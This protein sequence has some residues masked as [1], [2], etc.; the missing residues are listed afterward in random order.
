MPGWLMQFIPNLLPEHRPALIAS[1][2]SILESIEGVLEE[3]LVKNFKEGK[4]DVAEASFT[5]LLRFKSLKLFDSDNDD[6]DE[7][8]IAD[9]LSLPALI[10]AS[11]AFPQNSALKARI[12]SLLSAELSSGRLNWS[13]AA[14]IDFT[15]SS[16]ITEAVDLLL[17]MIGA[18]KNPSQV[19][20]FHRACL[21][22]PQLTLELLK[23]LPPGCDSQVLLEL[24]GAFFESETVSAH[25][26][27]EDTTPRSS[28]AGTGPSQ[29]LLEFMKR[30]LNSGKEKSFLSLL[31]ANSSLLSFNL[32][33]QCI[34]ISPASRW[35]C[36]GLLKSL[37]DGLDAMTPAQQEAFY[38]VFSALARDSDTVANELL[39]LLKKQLYSFD[40]AYKKIGAR[41]VV[42]F[43]RV[44]GGGVGDRW[45]P[46]PDEM[47]DDDDDECIAGCSQ[48]PA[49]MPGQ[50]TVS[51]HRLPLPPYSTRLIISLLE[52]AVKS[53]RSHPSAFAILLSGLSALIHADTATE[54]VEWIAEWIT[55]FFKGEFIK[56]ATDGD[57]DDS[58]ELQFD[59]DE[60]E[61]CLYLDLTGPLAGVAPLA[62]RLLA[63]AESLLSA[64]ALDA[65]DALHGCPILLIG[66]EEKGM[67]TGV[68]VQSRR[69]SC[70]CL[71]RAIVDAFAE[72]EEEQGKNEKRIA[73]ICELEASLKSSAVDELYFVDGILVSEGKSE[74]VSTDDASS[75][76]ASA[77]SD[78]TNV[79]LLQCLEST[80]FKKFTPLRR[81]VDHGS[82][83]VSLSCVQEH[84]A[85]PLGVLKAC[86]L[87]NSSKDS[88]EFCLREGRGRLEQEFLLGLW[89]RGGDIQSPELLTQL[90]LPTPAALSIAQEA[91]NSA[92]DDQV[93]VAAFK[94][95]RSW[96][97]ERFTDSPLPLISDTCTDL[98]TWLTGEEV[99]A[100]AKSAF[101]FDSADHV[102]LPLLKALLQRTSQLLAS[103]TTLDP[104]LSALAHL[105]QFARLNGKPSLLLAVLK[106]IRPGMQG[107]LKPGN[108]FFVEL[109]GDHDARGD[110]HEDK[111]LAVLRQ[112]QQCTR[113]LQVICSHVKYTSSAKKSSLIP[114]LKKDLEG[115]VLRVGAVMRGRGWGEAFWVGNLKHRALD[116]EELS[117]Q[118]ALLELQDED[119]ESN[120]DD[121]ESV[122]E[123]GNGLSKEFISDDESE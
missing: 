41:G 2:P 1:L 100:L 10:E 77:S 56:E 108:P 114:L 93:R 84:Y 85:L 22:A 66:A 109:Q 33:L 32:L 111:T 69:W 24:F 72:A 46:D 101:F 6:G 27:S 89:S 83:K 53:L 99:L 35:S 87:A 117:S 122:E 7:G 43:C 103:S 88:A 90:T 106:G 62:F 38:G 54:I 52:E 47:D 110:E 18:S 61:N 14:L 65:I 64:G 112:L 107:L 13:T 12:R 73:Q 17:L 48:M 92:Q 55:A 15:P 81:K 40:P 75:S 11:L 3:A 116:G 19:R 80:A 23:A 74:D 45:L 67:L 63:K 113:S 94:L 25:S 121:D 34:H 71:L 60:G 28:T 39:L 118:V 5:C 78:I 96:I 58:V 68:T 97:P 91:F 115:L 49:Q 76:S 102:A 98:V 105:L 31:A 119:E 37:L 44:L 70:L 51:K 21:N 86:L 30:F 9:V 82:Q 120:D 26:K 59:C 36:L 8:G 29:I 95:L 79:L 50:S 16:A 57:A 123:Q 42:V 4:R 20:I 104:L